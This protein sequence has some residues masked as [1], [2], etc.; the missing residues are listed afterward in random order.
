M[1]GGRKWNVAGSEMRQVV[2]GY[3]RRQLVEGGRQWTVASSGRWQV[4]E[5]GR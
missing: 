4:V 5:G 3:G 1:E 2:E